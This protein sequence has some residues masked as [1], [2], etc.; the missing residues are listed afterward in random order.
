MQLDTV[1]PEAMN[2][3]VQQTACP[4]PQEGAVAGAASARASGAGSATGAAA[5]KEAR[6]PRRKAER[7]LRR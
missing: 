6:R 2:W 5:A 7:I 3:P 1:A 4:P